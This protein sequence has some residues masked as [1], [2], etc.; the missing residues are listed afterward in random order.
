[1]AH[2]NPFDLIASRLMKDV[3]QDAE[4]IYWLTG[5][6]SGS[7]ALTDLDTDYCAHWLKARWGGSVGNEAR[8]TQDGRLLVSERLRS[9]VHP[10]I[11][12]ARSEFAQVNEALAGM[13][14]IE[15]G[16]ID[17]ATAGFLQEL[18]RLESSSREGA[19]D[20]LLRLL[21][22]A[23]NEPSPSAFKE[24]SLA[25]ALLEFQKAKE[26]LAAIHE[27]LARTAPALASRVRALDA[28]I[29][30]GGVSLPFCKW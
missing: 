29:L 30:P 21:K 7:G 5:H 9:R 27:Q 16:L 12:R 23:E 24:T 1:M 8:Q 10:L 19:E 28:L 25:V 20:P 15:A 14:A 6:G 11:L 26:R 2:A 3:G 17:G 18:T 22:E 4:G 13:R